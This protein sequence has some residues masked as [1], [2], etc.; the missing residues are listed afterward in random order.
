MPPTTP[1]PTTPMI[2]TTISFLLIALARIPCSTRD[3]DLG[4]GS[5]RLRAHAPARARAVAPVGDAEGTA[6]RPPRL[7]A[8]R[9]AGGVRRSRAAESH[10]VDHRKSSTAQRFDPPARRA[11]SASVRN[12]QTS[13]AKPR[14]SSQTR[15]PS[16]G[17]MPS[18]P[19]EDA[20]TGRP[21]AIASTTFSLVPPPAKSGATT[22]RLF[23]YSS[24]I[25]S[26]HPT[27]DTSGYE[28]KPSQ[29][30]PTTRRCAPG[31]RFLT[32]GHASRRNQARPNAF[33]FIERQER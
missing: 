27:K 23:E 30:T 28:P 6:S 26:R 1:R 14:G 25:E 12:R 15:R 11:R 24:A 5:A 9:R 3:P 7:A 20:T 31:T 4:F 33:G 32:N 16:D 2:L 17:A 21:A 8:P 19:T 10:T 29:P 18:A 13:A 22:R